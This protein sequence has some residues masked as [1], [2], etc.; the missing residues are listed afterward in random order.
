VD[1]SISS[2]GLLA[3]SCEHGNET[4]SPIKGGNFLTS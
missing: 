4:S 2:M 3:G 1:S